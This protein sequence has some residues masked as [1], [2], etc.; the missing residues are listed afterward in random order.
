MDGLVEDDAGADA[1]GSA[2]RHQRSVKRNDRIVLARID[3]SKSGL[4]PGRRLLERM[5]ERDQLDAGALQA[6]DIREVRSQIALNDNE[7]IG[8]EARDLAA[9]RAGKVSLAHGQAFS[10]HQRI[11]VGKPGAE[12]GIF[13]G[14]DAAMRQA[15]MPIGL[16]GLGP[17]TRHPVVARAGKRLLGSD[18]HV[19]ISL[20]GLSAKLLDRQL[21]ALF[22]YAAAPLV[23]A[24][25]LASPRVAS[26][27]SA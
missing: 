4:E 6:R 11:D 16:N 23:A 13:P 24:P 5:A 7:A 25:L 20:L 14:F 15:E 22:P 2:S 3:L 21:H 18:K 1:Q 10:L 9:K 19:E 27:N 17:Q 26:P 12:V 8:R